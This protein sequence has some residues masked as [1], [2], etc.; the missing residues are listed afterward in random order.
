M[1]YLHFINDYDWTEN[2]IDSYFPR[3]QVFS[4][5]L[6]EFKFKLEDLIVFHSFVCNT[7]EKNVKAIKNLSSQMP[8]F[9][10]ESLDEDEYEAALLIQARHRE[11]VG[12]YD[13]LNEKASSIAD[14][15]VVINLWA[16]IEQFSTRCYSLLAS[17]REGVPVESVV[18]PYR[19]DQLSKRYLNYQVDLT[20]MVSYSTANECRVLNNK[21]KH[22]H[23]VDNELAKFAHFK[24]K[25]NEPLYYVEYRLQDYVI[26][27]HHFIGS[28][29]EESSNKS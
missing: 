11:K 28:L 24:D 27:A 9:D 2:A 18:P 6:S 22:L 29:I 16:L 15:S 7:Y 26:A 21:I 19:W 12:Y 1:K 17:S 4:S 14:D 5:L 23:K 13:D 10:P 3:K 8:K 20:Q 25:E